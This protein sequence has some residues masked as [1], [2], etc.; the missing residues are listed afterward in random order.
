MVVLK[1]LKSFLESPGHLWNQLRFFARQFVEVFV[2]RS[3]RL[4]FIDHSVE[5]CHHLNREREVRIACGVR[6]TEFDALGFRVC[7]RNRNSNC[8]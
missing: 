4:D 3:V 8:C 7:P 2:N 1:R 5:S 6:R